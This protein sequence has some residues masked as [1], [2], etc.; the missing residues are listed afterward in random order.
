MRRI[1]PFQ[2][3]FM[4]FHIITITIASWWTIKLAK[5]GSVVLLVPT[6]L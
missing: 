6:A 3:S 2:A 4:R 5:L 1:C